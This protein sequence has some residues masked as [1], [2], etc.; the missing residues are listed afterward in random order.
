MSAR[1]VIPARAVDDRSIGAF[2]YA[3]AQF[4][5]PMEEDDDAGDMPLSTGLSTP[6]EDA[7]RLA[8]VDQ[9]IF[10]KLQQAE[11]DALD[12]ARKGYEEG[13]AAGEAEGRQFGD[14]QYRAHI[15]R[16]DGCL[17]DIAKSLALNQAAARD[18]ILAL[19]LAVGQYLAGREIVEGAAQAGPM[20]DAILAAHPFPG[21]EEGAVPVT[22]HMHPRD[23]EAL[24]ESAR[25]RSGV[26]LREDPELSRGS[27]R[28]EAADGVLD[29]TLERRT[30]MLMNLIQRFRERAEP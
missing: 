5:G 28:V 8:S 12:I 29:A 17:R 16:L 27:L 20:V 15:Q 13:F 24:S 1:R 4:G 6:E 11:R 30:A 26:L 23:L 2:P 18:E 10:E 7:R 25:P 21:S 22:V 3:Q 19:A 14:S 9:Q